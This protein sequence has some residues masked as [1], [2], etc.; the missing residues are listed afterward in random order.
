[1]SYLIGEIKTKNRII[2]QYQRSLNKLESLCLKQQ[3]ELEAIK[4]GGVK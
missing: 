2:G 1:M 4:Q 3:N